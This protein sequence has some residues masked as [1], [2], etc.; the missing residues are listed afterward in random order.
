MTI[1]NILLMAGQSNCAGGGSNL[2]LLQNRAELLTLDSNHQIWNQ[3]TQAF[4]TMAPGANCNTTLFGMQRPFHGIELRFAKTYVDSTGTPLYVVKHSVV[5]TLGNTRVGLPGGPIWNKK[6]G[7]IYPTMIAQYNAAVA[8]FDAADTINVVGFA[9]IQGESDGGAQNSLDYYRNLLTLLADVRLDLALPSLPFF[10]FRLHDKFNVANGN[11]TRA[12][13]VRSAQWQA[14]TDA[15]DPNFSLLDTDAVD[16]TVALDEIHYDDDG[17]DELATDFFA[18]TLLD[19]PGVGDAVLDADAP[20]LASVG[21]QELPIVPKP[22]H[23]PD[24]TI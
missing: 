12:N 7:E 22:R 11:Q 5:G 6:A 10:V 3:L 1:R 18:H 19:N 24:A 20:W 13:A 21:F 4:E 17:I 23:F 9:W 16:I 14:V 2:H 8:T 15:A